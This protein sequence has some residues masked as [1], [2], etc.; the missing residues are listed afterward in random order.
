METQTDK[1]VKQ[2][3][4]TATLAVLVIVG[5]FVG[6]ISISVLAEAATPCV[7]FQS[8]PSISYGTCTSTDNGNS[9]R[10]ISMSSP[11]SI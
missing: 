6:I 1:K 7:S 10:V 3:R 4:R 8:Y 11:V 2:Q 9:G 5:G